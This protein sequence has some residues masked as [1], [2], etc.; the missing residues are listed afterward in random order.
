MQRAMKQAM[1]DSPVAYFIVALTIFLSAFLLFLVQPLIAKTLLPRFGGSASVWAT[2]LV[3][4]QAALLCGYAWASRLAR[5]PRSSRLE[6]LH[7]VLLLA[8]LLL[9]PLAVSDK[10][11]FGALPPGAQVLLL[12]TLSVGLPFA[13]LATTSP[14]LQDWTAGLWPSRNPY[15]LFAISNLA[16]LVA[17]ASYPWL[18]EPWLS[19]ER[20]AKVWSF[21]YCAYVVFLCSLAIGRLMAQR[22][23][24]KS[25]VLTVDEVKRSQPTRPSRLSWIAL[26][27]LAS[28]ELLAVTN[29][30]TVNLPSVPMMWLLPLVIYLITFVL[31]FDN[32]RWYRPRLFAML[33]LVA[34]AAMAYMLLDKRL[35]HDISIQSPVFLACLFI[36]CM[37]CHGE[38]ARS[39]PAAAHLAR[40]YLCVALGGAIGGASVAVL[41]PVLLPAAFEVELGLLLLALATFMRLRGNGRWWYAAALSAIVL[42]LVVAGQRIQR[43]TENVIAIGRNFYGVVRVHEYGSPAQP[44]QHIRLLTHGGVLHGLQQMAPDRRGLP[45]T[46]YT[47]SSGIGRLLKVLDGRPLHVGIVGLGAGTLAA[48]GRAGDRYTFFEIDPAVV[49]AANKHFTY[50][51]DTAAKVEVLAGDGRIVLSK[52]PHA[53]FDVLA[54]DAFSGDAIPVH[55]LTREAVELYLSRTRSEGVVAVHVS[56]QYLDLRPVVGQIAAALKLHTA[57]IDDADEPGR[58]EKSSSAWILLSRSPE[59]LSFPAIREH[60]ID[61]PASNPRHLWTD[62]FSNLVEVMRTERF[63]ALWRS[64]ED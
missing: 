9:L 57:Y 34:I 38:L 19:I 13:L 55:L 35:A 24:Q 52:L 23:A 43:S 28:F 12:L 33:L 41:A 7:L 4:F 45:T 58:P 64:L 21:A 17:L 62:S 1:Q 5:Q 63:L 8:S 2:C 29:H 10:S 3:F 59:T 60:A 25:P 48:Y 14:L 54:V 32:D 49:D 30:L 40:F 22:D 26:A 6:R 42:A 39:R 37:F 50:T 56:N 51:R 61:L 16:S 47:A 15:R 27:A 36:A 20:Q 11:A 44:A 46:Y 31:C 18:I 53:E